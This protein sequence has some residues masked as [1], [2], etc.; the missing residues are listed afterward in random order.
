[1][2]V[3]HLVTR[4]AVRSLGLVCAA[5]V[6]LVTSYVLYTFAYK[7]T[8][9]DTLIHHA[10]LVLHL[11]QSGNTTQTTTVTNV[12]AGAA[13][14]LYPTPATFATATPAASI[15]FDSM[16]SLSPD[17][18]ASATAAMFGTGPS[19]S[20]SKD[21]S[22][23]DPFALS[24]TMRMTLSVA[25]FLEGLGL[26][27]PTQLPGYQHLITL[28]PYLAPIL[29][30]I[31]THQTL[32]WVVSL[33][34]LWMAA[35]LLFYIHFWKRLARAQEVDRVVKGPRSPEERREL[36]ERCMETVERGAGAR[37]W[38]ETWFDTGRTD[39]PARA[40]DIA[41]SNMMQWEAVNLTPSPAMGTLEHYSS[42]KVTTRNGQLEITLQRDP[43][44]SPGASAQ[45]RDGS[46]ASSVWKYT[47]GMLQS[48]NKMCFQGGILEVS[49]SLP[50][51]P[52]KAGLK[53]RVFVLGNLAR[54]GFPASMD[55][56]WPFSSPAT[57]LQCDTTMP[58]S[59]NTTSSLVQRL[60]GC[61]SGADTLGKKSRGA[62]E[63]TLLEAHY[64]LQMDLSALEAQKREI[65]NQQV[66]QPVVLKR[67]QYSK[68]KRQT[69][70]GPQGGETVVLQK[71]SLG[72]SRAT[73]DSALGRGA[74]G[75]SVVG[76][77]PHQSVVVASVKVASSYSSSTGSNVSST[78]AVET[79]MPQWIQPVDTRFFSSSPSP[80]SNNKD[81]GEFVKVGLEY[82][83]GHMNSSTTNDPNDD[84]YIQFSLNNQRQPPLLTSS[85]NAPSSNINNNEWYRDAKYLSSNTGIPQEPMSIVLSL[86][87][88]QDELLL[89]PELTFPAIMKIDYIRL[90]QPRQDVNG[91]K[92][93]LLCDP[94][95]HP[96]AAYIREHSRAYSD[97]GL[98][99]WAE[100]GYA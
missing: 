10:P 60:N 62:P 23:G 25:T 53:P 73:V 72:G 68:I 56:V 16:L 41:R 71:Q 52:S 80:P 55:G 85:S 8:P 95:G 32:A 38:V 51:S 26:R 44:S 36:F 46:G 69:D 58:S 74:S 78:V 86:G 61:S 29:A 19:S 63:M 66:N 14:Y 5:V 59:P 28:Q 4:S 40:E 84:A 39:R 22:G 90:Y 1:M 2:I 89:D 6:P 13:S 31:A 17:L 15:S 27:D 100:A 81:Q 87:L 76:A 20:S 3:D 65:Q 83:P 12:E 47:S 88:L 43:V 97:P 42:D 77:S 70:Q 9:L 30:F 49:V 91:K 33:L 64:G 21:V 35:E 99:S 7:E 96:T 34:H 48:W 93:R 57:P 11:L 37:K 45:K 82:W 92:D 24:M 54:Y 79:S 18:I 50:G 98:R 67:R 75:G 94:E